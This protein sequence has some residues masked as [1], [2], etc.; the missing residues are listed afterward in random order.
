MTKR[1]TT[2][3]ALAA[4][5]AATAAAQDKAPTAPPVKDPDLRAELVR[6]MKAEQDVRFEVAKLNPGNKPLTP[7]DRERRSFQGLQSAEAHGDVR[8]SQQRWSIEDPTGD[9][10]FRHRHRGTL[11][12]HI[13]NAQQ[14]Q[15]KAEN[16]IDRE[17]GQIHLR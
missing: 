7:A 3:A 6:R 5:L 1:L 2:V 12:E 4:L 16:P 13:E 8:Q 11:H 15:K 10:G 9:F 17:E 14:P